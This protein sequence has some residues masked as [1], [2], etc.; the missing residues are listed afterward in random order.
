MQMEALHEMKEELPFQTEVL[1][2]EN[3]NERLERLSVYQPTLRVR[4]LRL[5]LMRWW[6]LLLLRCWRRVRI[7]SRQGRS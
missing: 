2:L 3:R 1:E 6:L 5:V 4:P 7:S